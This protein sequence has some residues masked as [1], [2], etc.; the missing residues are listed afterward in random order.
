MGLN[1]NI[2]FDQLGNPP[3][4]RALYALAVLN[5]LSYLT[6]ANKDDRWASFF[7]FT[8]SQVVI[9][10]GNRLPNYCKVLSDD[11]CVFA[12]AGTTNV[13]QMLENILYSGQRINTDFGPSGIHS[14]F[15]WV[16]E[17]L[18]PLIENDLAAIAPPSRLVFT[19]HSL[20]AAAA[21]LLA[22]YFATKNVYT[23]KNYVGFGSPCPG[24]RE[25]CDTPRAFR[26]YDIYNFFDAVPHLPPW[27][28]FTLNSMAGGTAAP[29][30]HD[31][32]H[33]PRGWQLNP[34]G[35]FTY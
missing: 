4:K 9:T 27:A 30:F 26:A 12:I 2:L 17:C 8:S 20:G 7:G 13:A 11:G 23:V 3:D 22:C 15:L 1:K 16:A 14:F 31:W 34:N 21:Y 24:N 10:A 32:T 29:F 25:F 35:T 28:S 6:D 33:Q 5:N 18:V 19:G